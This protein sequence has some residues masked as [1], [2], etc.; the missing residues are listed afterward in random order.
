ML[1][2][3]ILVKKGEETCM[4]LQEKDKEGGLGT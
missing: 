1:K 2:R 4:K 3:V